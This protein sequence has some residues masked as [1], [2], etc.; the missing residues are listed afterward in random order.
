MQTKKNPKKKIPQNNSPLGMGKIYWIY[1]IIAIIF[2]GIQF[3]SINTS[4]S[5]TETEFLNK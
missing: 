2:L 3:T 5:I 1:G 4:Q